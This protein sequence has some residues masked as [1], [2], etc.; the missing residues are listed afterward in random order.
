MEDAVRGM[1]RIDKQ[2]EEKIASFADSK[3]HDEIEI[4][5]SRIFNIFYNS[6]LPYEEDKIAMLALLKAKEIN[7][8]VRVKSLAAAAV[9]EVL[10]RMS[11]KKNRYKLSVE[12]G[13]CE[14]TALKYSGLLKGIV[15]DIIRNNKDMVKK[16]VRVYAKKLKKSLADAFGQ[17]KLT[18]MEMI[19]QI[20]EFREFQMLDEEDQYGLAFGD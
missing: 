12:F 2:I 3:Y 20:N 11:E 6:K 9:Y 10:D 7:P 16:A 14:P 13:I 4:E 5:R 19:E 18:P 15:T 1:R 8:K 17:S